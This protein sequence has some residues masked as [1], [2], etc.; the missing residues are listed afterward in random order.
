MKNIHDKFPKTREITKK[1]SFYLARASER[2]TLTLT[3]NYH[4]NIC[5]IFHY[6]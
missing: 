5:S 2:V 4:E 6:I 1:P 3:Y